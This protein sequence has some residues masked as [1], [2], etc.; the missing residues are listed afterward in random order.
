MKKNV[1][2]GALVLA[3]ASVAAKI[4][5]AIYRIPLTNVLGAEG[6]GMYQL[7]F[8]VYALFITLS[9]SGFP[10][11][12]SRIVAEERI[13][14]KSG[15][16]YFKLTMML[17]CCFS[18]VSAAIIAAFSPKISALQGNSEVSYGYLIIAPALIFVGM[19]SAFRGYFQGCLNMIPTAVSNLI[20][21]VIK[22]A[23][24]LTLAIVLKHRGIMQSLYGA[25]FGVTVS[26][27]GAFIYLFITYLVKRKTYGG[28]EFLRDASTKRLTS[29]AFPIALVSIMLPL[30][31]F[32]DSFLIINLL[33]GTGMSLG[34]A[35][36]QYGLLSGPVGSLIN[37]PIVIM[38]SLSIAIVPAVAA[39][40]EERDLEGILKKSALSVKISYLIGLPCA[41]FII[42]FSYP[43]FRLLYPALPLGESA[44]AST[45]LTI[46]SIS[47]IAYSVM[48]IYTSLMQA[49]GK[50]YIPV[51]SLTVGIVIKIILTASLTNVIGILAP[52]VGNVALGVTAAVINRIYFSALVGKKFQ[53]VKNISM[54]LLSSVIMMLAAFMIKELKYNEIWALVVGAAVSVVL[55]FTL[56]LTLNTL[57]DEETKSLP[58]SN[59]L[60]KI[61]RTLRFWDRAEEK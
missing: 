57:S 3:A 14:G 50:T 13:R 61:K 7:V 9:V 53:L 45:M 2:S 16:G 19:I 38:L 22:L 30:S 4:I 52:A 48:Q 55:Y 41:L 33:R 35:T 47:I 40:K 59:A 5:G 32:I 29:V 11:A 23:L 6:M 39:G 34:E 56:V 15:E 58:F 37:M 17:L 25:L 36:A 8:P 51:I 10:V 24:G 26:E 18:V 46:S 43:I 54:I 44:L 20:E 12:L 60:L 21:Q 28:G 1:F 49:L 31:Q 42:I 27:F